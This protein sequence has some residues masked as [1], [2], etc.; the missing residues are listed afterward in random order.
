MDFQRARTSW[1]ETYLPFH[2][3]S[4]LGEQKVKLFP[5][6]VRPIRRLANF[7]CKRGRRLLSLRPTAIFCGCRLP[8]DETPLWRPRLAVDAGKGGGEMNREKFKALVHYV[9][10]KCEDPSRLGATKLNKILWYAETITF[11]NFGEELT[12]AKFVKRQFGPAPKAILPILQELEDDKALLIKNVSFYGF[13]KREFISLRSPTL[14]EPFTSDQIAIVD[15][16]IDAVCDE[17][18]AKS[19]VNLSHDEIWEM[20]S[21]GEELPIYTVLAEQ[22]E[23]TEEDVAWADRKIEEIERRVA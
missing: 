12:G 18:T 7:A 10:A 2:S 15:A 1:A 13:P 9:C 21:I 11:L 23:V 5:P 8:T 14:G 19:I 20:A 3:I 4:I 6:S 17:H 16:I 22:G